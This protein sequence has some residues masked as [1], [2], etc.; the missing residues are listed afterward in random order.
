MVHFRP[1]A[2]GSDVE[3]PVVNVR[4]GRTKKTAISNRGHA[5]IAG[6]RTVCWLLYPVFLN[7]IYERLA[8]EIEIAGCTRLVPITFLK[9]PQDELFSMASKLMP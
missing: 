3:H 1:A 6:A 9:G 5:S 2:K 7:P 4:G 8:T